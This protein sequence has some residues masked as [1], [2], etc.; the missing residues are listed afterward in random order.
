MFDNGGVHLVSVLW[1]GLQFQLMP[2]GIVD[3]NLVVGVS[4][5]V[6]LLA[7]QLSFH[8]SSLRWICSWQV[9]LGVKICKGTVS[10]IPRKYNWRWVLS[11]SE[12]SLV[13]EHPLTAKYGSMHFLPTTSSPPCPLRSPPS[14]P[15]PS[16][17]FLSLSLPLSCT[18]LSSCLSN[19]D[20]KPWWHDS[21]I[22]DMGHSRPGA[23]PQLS[24][25]V[26][27]RSTSRHCRLWHYKHGTFLLPVSVLVATNFGFRAEMK[28]P[29]NV[30]CIALQHDSK[31]VHTA[32][33]AQIPILTMSVFLVTSIYIHL[34]G[35]YVMGWFCLTNHKCWFCHSISGHFCTCKVMG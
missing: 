27:P 24:T 18:S 22:W 30:C 21:E 3:R 9:K 28:L 12:W 25:Y 33:I 1:S 26:L 35:Q 4:T 32:G 31:Q 15:L 13:F 5:V 20:G 7:L 2:I 10:W 16:S 11:L 8:L 29:S 14:P 23:V 34:I 19:T 6:K 17:L